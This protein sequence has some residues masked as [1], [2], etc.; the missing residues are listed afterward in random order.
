MILVATRRRL[1]HLS[2]ARGSL[3]TGRLAQYIRLTRPSH[4]VK[5]AFM[6]PGFAVGAYHCA[7]P[8]GGP[9]PWLSLAQGMGALCLASAANYVVNGILDAPHDARHPEKRSRPLALGSVPPARA[10][11]LAWALALAAWSLAW[12]SSGI[13]GA[14]LVVT[15]SVVGGVLYNVPPFRFKELPYLDVVVESANSPLRFLVGWFALPQD[16]WPDARW[17]LAYWAFGAFLMSGKRSAELR[18]FADH[19][20]AGAYR[21][22]YRYYTQRRLLTMMA[23]SA[24]A[25]VLLLTLSLGPQ[26]WRE[27]LV[28]APLVLAL[29]AWFLMLTLR[30]P[31]FP[32]EPERFSTAPGFVVFVLVVAVAF[33][34]VLVDGVSAEAALRLFAAPARPGS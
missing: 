2:S 10:W 3:T 24:S 17:L 33:Y 19:E 4:W 22:S 9:D 34:L 20:R 5:N 11:V 28:L 30:H 26:R 27:S 29:M 14:G 25:C 8:D 23:A 16:A 13:L 12:V 6:L 18:Y 1:G 32:R 31:V 15:F 21:R 7:L